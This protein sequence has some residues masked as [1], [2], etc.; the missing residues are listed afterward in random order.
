MVFSHEVLTHILPL[1]LWLAVNST[2]HG[3]VYP[4]P[5]EMPPIGRTSAVE[6]TPSPGGHGGAGI[7]KT[8]MLLRGEDFA[9]EFRGMTTLTLEPGCSIGEHYLKTCEEIYIAL[10]GPARFTVNGKTAELP[11]GAMV[12]GILHSS[13]GIYNNTDKSLRMLII[14]AGDKKSQNGFIDYGDDLTGTIPETPPPFP[15]VQLDK[16]LLHE[17]SNSH[18]GKGT[19]LFRRLW[20]PDSFDSKFYVFSHAII[21]SGSSIGYHQHNTR[22]E[23][24]YVLEG[25]GRYTVND[26][27]FTVGKGDALPCRIHDVHGIYNDSVND[28]EILIFSVSLKKGEVTDE[29]NLGD[30]LTM[31]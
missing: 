21:L 15:W 7:H 5:D 18:D 22:E 19:I 6:L 9:T 2:A 25:S 29:I 10:D 31:R 11:A 28:L 27:T 12:P 24:Y 26:S 30:D 8:A 14:T 16:S 20:N 4:I 23:I 17:A 13:H 1:I 3:Q